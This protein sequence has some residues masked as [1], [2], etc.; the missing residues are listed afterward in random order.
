MYL[1]VLGLGNIGGEYEKTRHNI[2]FEVLKLIA[3]QLGAS[4]QPSEV[5]YDWA[6]KTRKDGQLILACPRTYMNRSGLAA[7]ALLQANDL[8]PAQMLVVVDDFNL[9]LGR[10]RFRK[11][12][13][14]GGHNGLASIIEELET[15]NFLRLRVGIGPTPDNVSTVD[16]VLGEFR[17]DERKAVDEMVALA[18]EAVVFAIDH[19]LD[20]AMSKYNVNP[21]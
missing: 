13:S 12:G 16:F 5:E 1:T 10:L 9:P 18:A 14:D 8:D 2:G 6:T 21:A 20:E 4:A 11:S 15:E 19:R 7:H 17:A 3:R